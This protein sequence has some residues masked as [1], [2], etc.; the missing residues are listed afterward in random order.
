MGLHVAR[1]HQ[2]NRECTAWLVLAVMLVQM[3]APVAARA[4]A[5]S[6]QHAT[7]TVLS[8]VVAG[9][10]G[11]CGEAAPP[12]AT[13]S[14]LQLQHSTPLCKDCRDGACNVLGCV[15]IV[16]CAVDGGAPSCSDSVPHL[17]PL[18]GPACT[19]ELPYRP[20]IITL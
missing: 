13:E 19:A 9:D 12:A 4:H 14:S 7:S 2:R 15:P 20:P 1:T 18:L 17:S 3:A 6:A 11:H 10:H 16:V 5:V 8:E